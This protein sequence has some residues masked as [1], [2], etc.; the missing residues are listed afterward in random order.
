MSEATT[1]YTSLVS[2]ASTPSHAFQLLL[3]E[4][5][6]MVL[7]EFVTV[8]F[9]NSHN[10]FRSLGCLDLL[11]NGLVILGLGDERLEMLFGHNACSLH[12]S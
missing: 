8:F 9:S 4:F 6:Q 10:V 5:L 1:F 2:C 12:R 11:L 3:A 7:S